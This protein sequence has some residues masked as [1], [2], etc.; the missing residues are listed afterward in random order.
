[1][2]TAVSAIIRWSIFVYSSF[3]GALS[4]I[5]VVG[6][7]VYDWCVISMVLS[8]ITDY[9]TVL[10]SPKNMLWIYFL[11]FVRELITSSFWP[12]DDESLSDPPSLSIIGESN[13]R[14]DS[15]GIVFSI[16]VNLKWTKFVLWVLS[17]LNI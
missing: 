6:S 10:F 17:V 7:F 15:I 8:I 2:Y 16:S 11:S 9:W 12:S 13:K 4:V 5:K 1:M 3:K 14:F